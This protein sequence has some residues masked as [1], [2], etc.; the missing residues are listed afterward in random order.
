MK[1]PVLE[2]FGPTVQGE[3]MVAGQKTMFVRTGGC[4]YSCSWCD[5]AFTWDGSQKAEALSAESV[6]E[7]LDDTGGDRYN[8]V[9][10]SGGN[11]ALHK[12]IGE[13]VELLTDRGIQT[14]VETQG[15]YWQDW[16]LS[17]DDVTISPKP[18]SSTMVTNF[19]QLDLF[20]ERL[21]S[22]S[23]GS[24]SLKVVIFNDGDL[25]YAKQ[26]HQR[27]PHMPFYLQVGNDDLHENQPEKLRDHLLH[28]YEWL[29]DTVMEDRELNNVR[30][31][32][33]IHAL[34]WGNKQGV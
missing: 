16:L 5:S 19:E 6:L 10:I 9:T 14:A 18:P 8:H 12:G 21:S 32:P 1:I 28:R 33:Q 2:I 17:I 30:V 7:R 24:Q 3:G 4:D 27:Y 23:E 15:S 22:R 13:L 31:L 29:V 11:P 25:A 26:V 20:V 34:I